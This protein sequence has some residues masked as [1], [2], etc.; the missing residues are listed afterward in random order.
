MG[1]FV[2]KNPIEQTQV[3][4]LRSLHTVRY[5]T[6]VCDISSPFRCVSKQNETK[7]VA[8]EMRNERANVQIIGS[9]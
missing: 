4:S 8:Y 2:G 5:D 1:S 6:L 7:N 3:H 9:T